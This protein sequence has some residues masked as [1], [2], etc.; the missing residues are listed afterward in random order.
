MHR[1]EVTDSAWLLNPL[2]TLSYAPAFPLAAA[3]THAAAAG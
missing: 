1:N 3:R 2:R